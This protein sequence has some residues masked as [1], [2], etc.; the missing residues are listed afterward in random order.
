[1]NGSIVVLGMAATLLHSSLFSG[2][3]ILP[4]SIAC[5]ELAVYCSVET[6]TKVYFAFKESTFNWVI[7]E[8]KDKPREVRI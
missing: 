1:M 7:T 4:L 8:I 2:Y 5:L 6:F 3:A